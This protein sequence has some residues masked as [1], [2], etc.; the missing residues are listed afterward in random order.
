MTYFRFL[1]F[2]LVILFQFSCASV[3]PANDSDQLTIR[4]HSRWLALIEK[5][6]DE[7]YSFETKGYRESHTVEQYKTSFGRAV[8]WQNSEVYKINLDEMAEHAV[9]TIRLTIRMMVPGMGEQET[10]SVFKEDWLKDNGE[11]LH[12]KKEQQF[13]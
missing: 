11:W 12:Y 9:V 8:V 13:K 7:A 1:L 6:W 5:K 3:F 10:V 4:A 2:F